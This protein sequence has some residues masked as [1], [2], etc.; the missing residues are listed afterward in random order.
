MTEALPQHVFGLMYHDIV[1]EARDASF[2]HSAAVSYQ[3]DLATFQTQLD[4]I[5]VGLARPIGIE[6]YGQ[7]SE[8]KAVLLTFDDGGRSALRAAA[9]LEERGW[10]GHF[11][12]TTG[13]IGAA[14][15]LSAD[16]IRDLHR[17]GHVIGSHSH[18]HPNICYN[19]SR[20][21][22][23]AE[24]QRS[25]AILAEI[26][27]QAVLTA[28]VPGGDMDRQTVATAA[29]AGIRFLFT[30]E[31]TFHPWRDAEVTCFGRVCV[32]SN[33]SLADL[34]RFVQFKGFG[35]QMAIRR[36]KQ[37]IK[38]MLAPVYRRRMP[39]SYVGPTDR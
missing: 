26:V 16:D 22:M 5:S 27:G 3:V 15:F 25:C 1:E 10:R 33:T 36:C 35:R 30:S 7:V 12:I 39:R 34:Q 11:F 17:R 29:Q 13:L 20:Y 2:Q 38:R 37:W 19:L 4:A 6:Q 8:L 18:T 28:S 31:P 14:G 23:L 32:R 9:A 21:E 24:W